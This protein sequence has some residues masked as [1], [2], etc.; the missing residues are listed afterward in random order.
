MMREIK[1]VLVCGIG[2]VGSIYADKINQFDFDSLRVLVDE[3]RLEKYQKNPKIYNGKI[4]DLKY[5]LPSETS[6]KADL[7]IIATKFD[8]LASV[9]KN[10]KNFIKEDTVIISLLNGVISEE[11]IAKEY[12]WRNLLTSYFI[13]HS[14]M[15]DGNNITFDGVGKIVFGVQDKNLTNEANVIRLSKYFDKVGIDYEIPE[16]MLRS[17]WLKYMLNVACNQLSAICRVTFGQMQSDEKCLS[18]IKNVMAEVIAVAHSKGVNVEGIEQEAIEALKKMIPE[19]KT[20]MLQ[21]IEAGRKTELAL[22][23]T[24]MIEFGT[25]LKIPTPYNK[26][27]KELIEIIE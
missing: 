24:A 13:G 5:V 18:F 3:K 20:S 4:L 25:Q 23:A 15:R 6:Y 11:I 1:K 8:G 12:G 17:Y 16:D 9:I 7:I 14:A 21:D 26:I 19:G 2:A 27:M 10:L 22:F